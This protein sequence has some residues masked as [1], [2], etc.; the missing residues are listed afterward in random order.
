MNSQQLGHLSAL[1]GRP[2]KRLS[3]GT[4][5]PLGSRGGEL[6]VI[7]GRVWL[8]RSGE[9]EDRVVGGGEV[10][11]VPAS[12]DALIEA[13]DDCRPALVTWH[14]RSTWHRVADAVLGTLGR[15]LAAATVLHNG[16][17]AGAAASRDSAAREGHTADAA[18]A[19]RQRPRLVA[20]EA[21]CRAPGAA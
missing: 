10:V 12:G 16:D 20:Q 8:T 6:E 9:R 2:A 15:S 7:R 14:P 21:R 4:V 5:M 11:R 17:A 19:C 3:A 13:L 1:V 18:V